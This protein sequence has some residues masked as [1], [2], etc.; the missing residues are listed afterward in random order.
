MVR[1]GSEHVR[2]IRR[3]TIAVL[4]GLLVSWLGVAAL[5][6]LSIAWPRDPVPRILLGAWAV[7]AAVSLVIPGA[8]LKTIRGRGPVLAAAVPFLPFARVALAV[9]PHLPRA[10][11]DSLEGNF[12]RYR[13][14]RQQQKHPR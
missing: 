1:L 12:R 11:Q 8:S 6:T 14:A 13:W 7:L 2:G 3:L 10:V 4:S 5:I 9:W